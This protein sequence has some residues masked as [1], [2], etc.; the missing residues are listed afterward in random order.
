MPFGF[1]LTM[2]TLPSGEPQMMASG[3]PWPV[4]SFRFR[5]RL[6][7]SIPFTFSGPRGITPAFGYSAPHSSARGTSTLLSGALLS[8]HY[9]AVRLLRSVHVRLTAFA[10]PD[11]SARTDTTE[12]SRFSCMLFLDVHGVS[13][14]AGPKA[15]SRSNAGPPCGLPFNVTRSPPGSAFTKLNTQPADASIYASPAASRRPTQ[16]SRSGWIRS[17]FL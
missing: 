6:G 9:G 13:D 1:H 4:S 5:A 15:D 16:D 12:V 3:P 11:R 17:P 10:F 8:A 14:Y 7:F 2:D